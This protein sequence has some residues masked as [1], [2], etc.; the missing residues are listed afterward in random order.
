MT[1]KLMAQ[2]QRKG[3]SCQKSSKRKENDDKIDEMTTG[4]QTKMRRKSSFGWKPMMKL[5]ADKNLPKGW[6]T[7]MK[8]A[9]DKNLLKGWK[10][11]MKLTAGK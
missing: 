8:L 9:T 11:M 1:M 7:M 3:K 10:S 4:L 6:K 2:N 5:T